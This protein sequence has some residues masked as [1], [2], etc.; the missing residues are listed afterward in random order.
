M[1][2]ESETTAIA[3]LSADDVDEI[4]AAFASIG[5][6]KPAELYRRYLDEQDLVLWFTRELAGRTG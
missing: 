3:G 5:W 1:R 2:A 4:V 6:H